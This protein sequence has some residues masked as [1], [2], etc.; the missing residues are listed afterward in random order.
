MVALLGS[1][2]GSP[3]K[4]HEEY[5][6]VSSVASEAMGIGKSSDV[7]TVLGGKASCRRKFVLNVHLV[8]EHGSLVSRDLAVVASV[9]YAHD[10]SPVVRDEKPFLAE[11]PLF[12]TFNGVEFPAQDRP[13]RMVSGRAS[14]KL[15]ISLLSSKCD[16]R[17]FCICFT[18]QTAS[19]DIA[20]ISPPCYSK[21]I[22]SIS[23]KRTQS[24]SS[25]SGHHTVSP[26]PQLLLTGLETSLPTTSSATTRGGGQ[27]NNNNV[28]HNGGCGSLA[29]ASGNDLLLGSTK[30]G[31]SPSTSGE[32][33]DGEH[34]TASLAGRANLLC[35]SRS[36]SATSMHYISPTSVAAG[37]AGMLSDVEDGGGLNGR[38][39]GL[40]GGGGEGGGTLELQH[41]SPALANNTVGTM[42]GGNDLS[43]MAPPGRASGGGGLERFIETMETT[44]GSTTGGGMV[45]SVSC[46][47][48][49]STPL[50]NNSCSESMKVTT[51]LSSPPCSLS[52]RLS[53]SDSSSPTSGALTSESSFD[54]NNKQLNDHHLAAA[55]ARPQSSSP[56][57]GGSSRPSSFNAPNFPHP[58]N[59][60]PFRPFATVG[61]CKVLTP[62]DFQL[63]NGISLAAQSASRRCTDG[64]GGGGQASPSTNSLLKR[65]HQLREVSPACN[66]HQQQQQQEASGKVVDSMVHSFT[67]G[68]EVRSSNNNADDKFNSALT[69]VSLEEEEKSLQYIEVSLQEVSRE[70]QRRMEELRSK[71][72]RLL[73]DEARMHSIIFQSASWI[74]SLSGRYSH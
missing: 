31:A 66:Q 72:R 64:G 46:S 44:S 12:T 38:C 32:N 67:L 49:S 40:G 21:P 24:S 7:L 71:R 17:L 45:A 6:L 20:P 68:T 16:N 29:A 28:N 19:G 2:P 34:A 65:V 70:V 69:E 4:G 74:E 39:K 52:L 73:E 63:G 61:P 30:F 13:T 3:A 42:I 36:S 57:A 60:R 59:A 53:P 23:R 35:S 11:P 1:R 10:H 50:A 33:D 55:T 54:N 5:R 56:L 26:P 43:V 41:E 9:A 47:P 25:S 58:A 22:R 15:A 8:D 37:L 51:I 48:V 18:P 62:P 27:Y 14:F